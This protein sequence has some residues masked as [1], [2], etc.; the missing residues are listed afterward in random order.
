M[1]NEN[2]SIYLADIYVGNP[3]QKLRAVFDTGSSNMW[4]LNSK[5]KRLDGLAYDYE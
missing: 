1:M 2:D 5:L 4:V 3:P